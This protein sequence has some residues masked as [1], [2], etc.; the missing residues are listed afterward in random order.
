MRCKKT[1]LDFGKYGRKRYVIAQPTLFLLRPHT[2]N[3]DKHQILR[4]DLH[5]FFADACP[6]NATLC[7]G[8]KYTLT[9]FFSYYNMCSRDLCNFRNFVNLL[10]CEFTDRTRVN[11]TRVRVNNLKLESTEILVEVRMTAS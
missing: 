5:I 10:I 4:Y 11:Q 2:S 1:R 7:R 9:Y 8:H 6:S 3:M